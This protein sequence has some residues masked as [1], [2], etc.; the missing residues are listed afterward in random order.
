MRTLLHV[1]IAG[2][3]LLLALAPTAC[4][5]R[6]A[7]P[8][9]VETGGNPLRPDPAGGAPAASH[10]L[11]G[12]QLQVLRNVMHNLGVYYVGYRSEGRPPRTR[13]EF[14]AR[15]REEGPDTRVLVQALDK[16][17]LVLRLDP[18]PGTDQVLGHEKESFKLRHDRLV[19]LGGGAV[20][21][22]TDAEFEEALKR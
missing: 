12:V 15:L 7:E 17:W 8:E 11:R 20:V 21:G 9:P 10:E 1:L 18:P 6:N 22:M 3:V 13:D 4:R 5:K 19:L 16:D 2:I 14:K